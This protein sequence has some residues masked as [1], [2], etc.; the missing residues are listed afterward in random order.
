MIYKIKG[1]GELLKGGLNIPIDPDNRHYQEFVQLVKEHG[2]SIVEGEDEYHAGYEEL[3]R[4]AYPPLG[5]QFD[6]IFHQD[7]VGW[8]AGIAT[9]KERYPKSIQAST[10]IKPLPQWL[11]DI[12]EGPDGLS[13]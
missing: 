10:T 8:K 3:R 5:E 7:V 1:D 9:I 6:I 13:A 2:A 4:D 11:M 12:I